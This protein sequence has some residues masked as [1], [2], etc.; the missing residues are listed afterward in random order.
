MRRAVTLL[1]MACAA[2]IAAPVVASAQTPPALTE[3]QIRSGGG[4][5]L[6]LAELKPMFVGNTV[7][8]LTLRQVG[9][10]PAGTVGPVWH[11]DERRRYLGTGNNRKLE[12]LWWFDGDRYCNELRVNGPGQRCYTLW[13]TAG[14]VYMCR[15][16]EGECIYSVRSVP[17]NPEK[18]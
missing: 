9:S 1:S 15:Q 5:Q 13:E 2:T 7:Y 6:R 10:L 4:R 14:T 8:M 16:P 11:P 18:L 3:S 12:A 17:G